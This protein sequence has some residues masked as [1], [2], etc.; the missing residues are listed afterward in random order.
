MYAEVL[1]DP[2]PRA[3]SS[4]GR[5]SRRVL[6]AGAGIT[7][8]SAC[9]TAAAHTQSAGG[10][11]SAT[12][13]PT[14][15]ASV[16]PSPRPTPT[17][18]PTHPKS[19]TRP[20]AEVPT[21]PQYYVD[22][23]PKVI[24]LTLDDGPSE[25]TPQILEI[26]RDHNITATFCMI[27]EQIRDCAAIVR[28]VAAAGHHITNHTWDHSDQT[29]LSLKAVTSQIDRTNQAMADVGITA[30]M[31]RAPS[32]P[33][34]TPSSRPRRPP[35]CGR[36][37]GRSTRPT[38]PG[39]A[40][41]ASSPPSCAP[42]GPA[43]SSWTTT[44]AGTARRRSPRCGSG[45]PA[46]RRGLPV[47]HRLRPL[48][49]RRRR[50]R[51]SAARKPVIRAA[52]WSG[53]SS[54]ERWPVPSSTV[55]VAVGTS[56]S[57]RPRSTSGGST[58]SW[59]PASTSTGTSMAPTRPEMSSVRPCRG[60]AVRA[61]APEPRLS[62]RTWRRSASSSPPWVSIRSMLRSTASSLS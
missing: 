43:R 30:T 49:P 54:G 2:S 51:Y 6:L 46:A 10:P 9:G 58:L 8:L 47:H 50:P 3:G 41:T 38:G 48:R 4:A 55:S 53:T 18:T 14:A 7:L 15:G 1:A 39:P 26:L 25:Y 22:A 11:A 17:P 35:D 33:G 44:A 62:S 27:G 45:S 31:Y 16:P 23:G 19:T 13:D 42:P 36:W 12:T 61:C 56:G 59:R 32:A 57:S 40:S 37:T 21:K 20:L 52:T 60:Q 24:A 29:K 34:T 5:V 28:D